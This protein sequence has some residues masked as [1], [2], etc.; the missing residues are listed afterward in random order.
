[1]EAVYKSGGATHRPD[2]DGKLNLDQ[3]SVISLQIAP[4]SVASFERRGD[5]LVL[6][7]RDGREV[8]VHGFFRTYDDGRNDLVLEDEAGVLWWG[9]YHSPWS[10]FHFTEIEWL[11]AIPLI[12]LHENG[13]LLAGV[14][15][16]AL[17]AAAGGGGGGSSPN[18]PPEAPSYRHST[19]EDQPL[20]NRVIGSDPD[21]DPLGYALGTPPAHGTGRRAAHARHATE[22]RHH[23]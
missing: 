15:A 12:P 21:G 7:L 4:E 22:H 23:R 20:R 13:G 11:D 9:Q 17:A 2:D 1:M 16:L 6:V 8:T 10:E 19:P 5:D 3:P 18:T 14:G